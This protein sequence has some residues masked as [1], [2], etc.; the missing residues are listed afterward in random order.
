VTM[1]TQTIETVDA[2][3]NK[4]ITTTTTNGGSMGAAPAGEGGDGKGVG[5]VLTVIAGACV[6][7]AIVTIVYAQVSLNIRLD[8]ANIDNL[9]K[10]CDSALKNMK[11]LKP[12]GTPG[13]V[14]NKGNGMFLP[15]YCSANPCGNTIC[16]S[17]TFC[18]ESL[19]VCTDC[20]KQSKCGG[21][22]SGDNECQ[23]VYTQ[24]CGATTNIKWGTTS[25]GIFKPLP[26]DIT[27]CEKACPGAGVPT[28]VCGL[29]QMYVTSL[30]NDWDQISEAVKLASI[31]GTIIGTVAA[32]FTLAT[33]LPALL[34]GI[35]A[36]TGNRG[37][38]TATAALSVAFAVVGCCAVVSCLLAAVI[39]AAALS[40]IEDIVNIFTV[41][42]DKMEPCPEACQ[43]A[44]QAQDGAATYVKDYFTV[45]SWMIGFLL[46]FSILQTTFSI[47]TCC[48]NKRVNVQ[49]SS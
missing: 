21:P 31:P 6:I 28:K 48:S 5:I 38:V 13:G 46:L 19:N 26:A 18:S 20:P 29:S 34:N 35:F 45:L 27:S 49:Y 9:N 41:Y 12:D 42:N 24:E 15:E 32:S 8:L 14:D 16:R 3:G 37:G 36:M 2:N 1:Q 4:T 43:T 33:A 22:T 17:D 10:E 47:V 23:S 40:A 11:P 25:I 44:I 39:T 7:L 30:C